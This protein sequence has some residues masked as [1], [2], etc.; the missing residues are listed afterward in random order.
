MTAWLPDDLHM[1]PNAGTDYVWEARAVLGCIP[2]AA[3]GTQRVGEDR[4]ATGTQ[5]VRFPLHQA[6]ASRSMPMPK[7]R[8]TTDNGDGPNFGDEPFD[9]KD[10]KAATDDAQLSL[11]AM[12][13]D[14]RPHG[15][16]AC[17]RVCVEDDTGR[18]VYQAVLC[19]SSKDGADMGSRRPR[20]RRGSDR[21]CGISERPV[22]RMIF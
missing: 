17:W 6:G 10:E 13:F 15:K 14:M 19:F 1:Y 8:V 21:D 7:F 18:Q 3:R 2:F 22:S 9:F 20:I 5:T 4:S 12:A 16:V 11:F